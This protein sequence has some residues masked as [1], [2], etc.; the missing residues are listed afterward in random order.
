MSN[1]RKLIGFATEYYTLWN[2]ITIEH[3]KD[4]NGVWTQT[5]TT[6]KY[7]YIQ[8]LSKDEN[9]ALA[10]FAEKFN[11]NIE[12]IE[13][14]ESLRG[15]PSRSFEKYIKRELPFNVFPWGRFMFFPIMEC[16][17]IYQ[18]KRVYSGEGAI[19]GSDEF[20]TSIP[21]RRRALARRRLIQ[22]GELIKQDWMDKQWNDNTLE[23][24]EVPSKYMFKY[25][26]ERFLKSKSSFWSHNNGDKI[27]K[28]L[29]QIKS[30]GY[31]SSFGYVYII[32]Y[33]SSEE[34]EYSYKG[35]N[36]PNIPNDGEFHRIQATIKNS[37]YKGIKQNLIQRVKLLE[38][39]PS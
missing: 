10:K 33:I 4:I 7:N 35:S 19:G 14:D 5:G 32:T 39:N 28:D 30:T 36:P 29:K 18:L 24:D 27:I 26:Y 22:L 21:M 9:S 1:V 31:D 2:E 11:V 38:L 3:F 23:W 15:I 12:D 37:E 6:I 25:D 8:N 17:D 16:D 34:I 13:V 20:E